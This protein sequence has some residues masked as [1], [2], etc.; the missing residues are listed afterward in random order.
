MIRTSKLRTALVE[1]LSWRT[2][3]QMPRQYRFKEDGQKDLMLT[4]EGET[5]CPRR[6]SGSFDDVDSGPVVLDLIQVDGRQVLQR[7]T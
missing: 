2:L 3:L 4:G 5:A 6:P 7:C 1:L